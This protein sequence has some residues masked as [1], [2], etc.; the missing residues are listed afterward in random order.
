MYAMSPPAET[1][2][3][4]SSPLLENGSTQTHQAVTSA[5]PPS[6]PSK[7][8]HSSQMAAAMLSFAVLGIFT[9]S[10]GVMVP[11][12]QDEFHL[13]EVQ[14]SL[15]FI[16]PPVG[17]VLAAQLNNLVH[18][19]FGQRGIAIIG[20]LGHLICTAAICIRPSFEVYLSALTVA[21]VGNAL[22]DSAWSSWAATMQNANSMSGL[23]HGSFS[24][25]A[26][27]GPFLAASIL[28]ARHAPWYYWYFILVRQPSATLSS[29][30]TN[31]VRH[32]LLCWK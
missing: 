16:I 24:L 20:P 29:I 2:P 13:D 22:L 10:V 15:A 25:G 32:S 19:H 28:S 30:K 3:D 4:E 18:L 7:W 11:Y 12:L 5:K 26:G 31:K 23:L 17:Y 27:L 21:A 14:V 6:T 9:S 8:R 1:T